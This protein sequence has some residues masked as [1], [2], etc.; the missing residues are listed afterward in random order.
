[1]NVD[2]NAGSVALMLSPSLGPDRLSTDTAQE[3]VQYSKSE[4]LRETLGS[5]TVSEAKGMDPG[6]ELLKRWSADPP[7]V[8]SNFYGL[9][10]LLCLAFG[11]SR[12]KYLPCPGHGKLY[13]LKDGGKW[14]LNRGCLVQM[15]G[16][17]AV[18]LGIDC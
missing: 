4:Y 6:S 5:L 7:S 14:S 15:M 18:P 16:I 3:Y 1:M 2:D 11:C 12:S 8:M 13:T 9:F 10:R 17:G